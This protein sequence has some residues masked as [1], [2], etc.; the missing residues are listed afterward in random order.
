M[1]KTQTIPLNQKG[2][3]K[4]RALLDGCLILGTISILFLESNAIWFMLPLLIVYIGILEKEKQPKPRIVKR[5][6]KNAKKYIYYEVDEKTG[7]YL[8]KVEK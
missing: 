3:G 5:W 2:K 8:K 7:Q 4:L 1:P 6:H